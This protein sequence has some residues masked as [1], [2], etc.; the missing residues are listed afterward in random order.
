MYL[1]AQFVVTVYTY[2]HRLW[3]RCIWFV[4]VECLQSHDQENNI[5]QFSIVMADHSNRDLNDD[6]EEIRKYI[7]KVSKSV[8]RT[9]F[10]VTCNCRGAI[11][12][13]SVCMY[14]EKT[15]V[16]TASNKLPGDLNFSL[17]L[18]EFSNKIRAAEWNA[19]NRIRSNAYGKYFLSILIAVLQQ[20]PWTALWHRYRWSWRK[21]AEKYPIRCNLKWF[22]KQASVKNCNWFGWAIFRPNSDFWIRR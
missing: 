8:S 3:F 20:Q 12:I 15:Q 19:W 13:G 4:L 11:N 5:F 18:S 14:K 17:S 9:Y 1:M 21:T 7:R 2:F 22:I 6:Q 10:F 16:K